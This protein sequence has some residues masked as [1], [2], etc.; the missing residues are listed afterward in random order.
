MRRKHARALL[1]MARKVADRSPCRFQVAC[2]LCD[3][4]GRVV[5]SGHNRFITERGDGRP[6]IHAEDVAL[7][8]VMKPSYNLEAFIY[9]DGGK[10]IHPCPKCTD[11]L[12]SYGVQ[13]VWH[14]MGDG[15]IE[16]MVLA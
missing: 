8:R 1:D 4:R 7:R 16:R 10:P 5:A 13:S 15:E 6:T 12:K 2:I 11:M 14:T 3:H 9:R